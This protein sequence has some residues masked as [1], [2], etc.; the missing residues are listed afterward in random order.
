MFKL[1]TKNEN[2]SEKA[3][4]KAAKKF[5][6]DLKDINLVTFDKFLF[7]Y[8]FMMAICNKKVYLLTTENKKPE[9]FE[10]KEIDHIAIEKKTD[11]NLFLKNGRV[12]NLTSVVGV[13]P[14][15]V[16]TF[17]RLEMEL[18]ALK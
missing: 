1:F 13:K 11:L 12:I 18:K 15:V 2:A 9:I 8:V 17:K 16:R 14:V 5:D 3:F 7:S 10:T 4:A 6:L